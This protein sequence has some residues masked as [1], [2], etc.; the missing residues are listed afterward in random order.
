MRRFNRC[1]IPPREYQPAPSRAAAS[2]RFDRQIGGSTAVQ[3]V[4]ARVDAGKAAFDAL[5]VMC[6]FT[7]GAV[8]AQSCS[9]AEVKR[10][11]AR[12]EQDFKTTFVTA[13]RD[14]FLSVPSWL[15]A[16]LPE[17]AE[18]VC[19]WDFGGLSWY[20]ESLESWRDYRA[21]INEGHNAGRMLAFG[22]PQ[23][24]ED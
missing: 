7:W 20:D 4:R 2:A 5:P 14:G 8:D 15:R 23:E 1:P 6:R 3:S 18:L 10:G 17:G 24:F 12:A 21:A 16:P 13:A 9:A 19:A 22:M 11:Q